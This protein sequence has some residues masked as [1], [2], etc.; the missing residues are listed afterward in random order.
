MI[1]VW[2]GG[3]LRSWKITIFNYGFVCQNVTCKNLAQD[4]ELRKGGWVVMKTS[5]DY[6]LLLRGGWVGGFESSD[7]YVILKR[8]LRLT[9]EDKPRV[10]MLGKKSI[11]IFGIRR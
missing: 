4:Y 11:A 10:T 9:G 7:N 6:E 1:T 3:Y 2:V 8:S 5:N